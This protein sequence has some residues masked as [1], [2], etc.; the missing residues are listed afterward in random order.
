M[1]DEPHN[2]RD[3]NKKDKICRG[4]KTKQREDKE[5]DFLFYFNETNIFF[6][7]IVVKQL[8]TRK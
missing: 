4:I 6:S 1:D 2:E 3:Q 7:L 5:L 8:C